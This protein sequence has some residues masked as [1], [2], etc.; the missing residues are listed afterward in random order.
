MNDGNSIA[1]RIADGTKSLFL[2]VDEN[3]AAVLRLNASQDFHQRAFARTI[4]THHRQDFAR[5]H[6]K[7]HT[8]ERFDSGERFG[9]VANFQS[10]GW[11]R[12]ADHNECLT[13]INYC[14]SS[15]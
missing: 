13:A 9:D 8:L 14:R 10:R 15:N 1:H 2:P 3:L 12:S 7:T 4:L 11:D 5:H 6:A